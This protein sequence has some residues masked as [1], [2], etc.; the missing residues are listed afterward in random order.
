MQDADHASRVAAVEAEFL[1]S[2]HDS[3]RLA[4][5]LDAKLDN[6][7]GVGT[8]F[9]TALER[10]GQGQGVG[11]GGRQ[12]YLDTGAAIKALL[13][14]SRQV[15]REDA[16]CRQDLVRAVDGCDAV[17]GA[18]S[19]LALFKP[20]KDGGESQLQT[21]YA[22]LPL[23][24]ALENMRKL[25][26]ANSQ[27][28]ENVLGDVQIDHR[29][30]HRDASIPC[31][32]LHPSEQGG[33]RPSSRAS[34]RAAGHPSE[35]GGIR[36][37]SRASVRAGGHP[38]EQRGIRPSSRA[39]VRAGG[40]PS[41]QQGIRPSRGASVRAGGHP[42]EQQGIRLSS[43]ASVRASGRSLVG[44]APSP[45]P[46]LEWKES[47]S[48]G[49][50]QQVVP[51]PCM[52]QALWLGAP[53]VEMALQRQSITRCI[54]DLSAKLDSWKQS[55]A[56][57]QRLTADGLSRTLAAQAASLS[58]VALAVGALEAHMARAGV[59][60]SSRG[61]QA[62]LLGSNDVTRRTS[63]ADVHGHRLL[64]TSHMF[65]MCPFL[66][67]PLST[68]PPPPTA[69]EQLRP[70]Q[71]RNQAAYS[72]ARSQQQ[73]RGSPPRSASRAASRSPSFGAESAPLTAAA[74]A[75]ATPPPSSSSPTFNNHSSRHQQ[76]T[77]HPASPSPSPS[78]SPQVRRVRVT[79]AVK[80]SPN[81]VSSSSGAATHGGHRAGSVSPMFVTLAAA[82]EAASPGSVAAA[83]AVRRTP[84]SPMQSITAAPPSALSFPTGNTVSSGAVAAGG[85]ASFAQQ[86]TS[87]GGGGGSMS[88]GMMAGASLASS[89]GGG[90]APA[91]G[92]GLGG[93]GGFG[94]GP[95]SGGFGSG[96]GSGFGGGGG[97]GGSGFGA[98]APAAVQESAAAPSG[99]LN[100]KRSS[101][102]GGFEQQADGRYA[103]L[104]R[105]VEAS[106]GDALLPPLPPVQSP[107]VESFDVRQLRGT[108]A[109]ATP[110]VPASRWTVGSPAAR[111]KL[112]SSLLAMLNSD[113]FTF[114]LGPC[115]AHRSVFT[116]Q[117]AAAPPQTG[118][119]SAAA[120][121]PL[122]SVAE[123]PAAAAAAALSLGQKAAESAIQRQAAAQAEQ[124]AKATAASGS[125]LVSGRASVCAHR[126]VDVET[127]VAPAALEHA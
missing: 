10:S 91:F 110:S 21:L 127:R 102:A 2:L 123:H 67:P 99:R 95:G 83:G 85:G 6:F 34:V 22:A 81:Y 49:L 62:R 109:H 117:A 4:A 28:R 113:T 98:A 18:M 57:G 41:E 47:H 121:P 56:G 27:E 46:H 104:A 11:P 74:A 64:A 33:I 7:L 29:C 58:D 80:N 82:L 40:H 69:A 112:S 54:D 31:Q 52:R 92:S 30:P 119:G 43:G 72:A 3:R 77:T 68:P 71:P 122:G 50:Q 90:G 19:A 126:A 106:S 86:R 101:S 20:A 93:G 32:F 16:D 70:S 5:Q 120:R 37:S 107:E 84:P 26:G 79:S 116:S 53:K 42:S 48:R 51:L 78:P 35:Q 25:V 87:G 94:T 63:A 44:H 114:L 75:A 111:K 23:D 55:P 12:T 9:A 65:V 59:G 118:W 97:L 8:D 1:E 60:S 96:P 115:W 36:P 88:G 61:Q 105:G 14:T 89:R 108:P 13:D 17:T 103:L 39:S 24:P 125:G 100:S 38:F 15:A 76:P 66:T 45:F 73:A 124:T